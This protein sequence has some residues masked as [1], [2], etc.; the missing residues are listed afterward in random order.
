[1]VSNDPIYPE[2]GQNE[3]PTEIESICTNCY[4]Q[5]ITKILLTKIPLFR[6]VILMSFTCEHCDFSNNE[7]MSGTPIQTTGI[8]FVVTVKH[9]EDMNRQV[10]RSEKCTFGI[11]E[12]EFEA[13]PTGA[14]GLLTTIEG[15]LIRSH[16]ELSTHAS[17]LPAESVEEQAHKQKF[18]HFLDRM[19]DCISLRRE[20][21]FV[22]DDPSGN[23]FVEQYN[24]PNTDPSVETSNYIRTQ[25]QN[26]LLMVDNVG[27]EVESLDD[28]TED[29]EAIEEPKGKEDPP[30]IEKDEIISFTTPCPSCSR[31][32]ETN[33]KTV[34]VPYFK[35]VLL[36]ATNC[37][38]CGFRSNEVK[39][40]KGI[41]EKGIRYELKMTSEEDLTRDI[42]KTH[43]ATI[44]I[45]ELEISMG[46]TTL[47]G[48]FTTIEGLI[49]NVRD[50]VITL[51][52]YM[53]SSTD[54]T[55]RLKEIVSKLEL[56]KNGEMF[57]TLIMD[58]PSGN[59]YIQ[60]FYAPDPDP[61]ML[62]VHYE[63]SIEQNSELGIDAMKT[64]NY[65]DDSS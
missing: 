39:P 23:S 19:Q 47:G 63:R 4:Q 32:C 46:A 41:S 26:K 62:V 53:D 59:S 28:D 64:E 45:E 25:E 30:P 18:K 22:L 13:P 16:G 2:L 1:M 65:E 36:M 52:P 24:A 61:N 40:S 48:K 8:K 31:D 5:G 37:E 27:E 49:S 10:V 56:V 42:L 35:E 20:F 50:Q 3:K 54:N 12:I 55:A 33:M 17:S 11:P 51:Y 58:D 7:V 14:K 38:I 29:I 34:S 60:S 21:T 44:S 6:D 9:S 43:D 57:V 15:L